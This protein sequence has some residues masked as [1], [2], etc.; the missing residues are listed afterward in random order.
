MLRPRRRWLIVQNELLQRQKRRKCAAVLVIS[1]CSVWHCVSLQSIKKNNKMRHDMRGIIKDGGVSIT[2]ALPDTRPLN[3]ASEGRRAQ[4]KEY[5]SSRTGVWDQ[6]LWHLLW[7]LWSCCWTVF[8]HVCPS[9][10][11]MCVCVWSPSLMSRHSGE[12]CD[13]CVRV[14][15]CWT[16]KK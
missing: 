16:F 1:G 5:R 11:V 8:V 9:V 3:A 10:C 14:K 2:P 12:M 15:W 7:A 6:S 13:V 4:N